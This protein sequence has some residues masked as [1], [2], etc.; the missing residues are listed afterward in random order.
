[1]PEPLFQIVHTANMGTKFPYWK[2][3]FDPITHKILKPDD[4]EE[5]FAPEENIQ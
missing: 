4:W 3:H 5:R 2:A 1:D